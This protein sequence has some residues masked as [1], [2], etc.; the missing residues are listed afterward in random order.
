MELRL[1]CL[2]CIVL[3]NICILC[4]ESFFRKLDLIIDFNLNEMRNRVIIRRL[5]N[6]I[7]CERILDI[8]CEVICIRNSF[9]EKLWLEK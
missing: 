1:V 8:N 2:V 6:M 9:V 5:L 3:Y 4:G 7:E